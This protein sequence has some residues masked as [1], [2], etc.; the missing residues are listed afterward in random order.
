MDRLA[1]SAGVPWAGRHFS[2]T[3]F[4][5]DD[6]SAPPGL[7]AAL[8]ALRAG[9]G[10]QAEVL[11]ALRGVRLLVPLL[12]QLGESGVGPTGLT[13]DKSA[14][15]ALVTVAAPDGRRVLPTFTS[16]DAMRRWNPSARPIPVESERIALAAAAEGT[17]LVVLD[18]LSETEFVVRR[19]A[20]W[21]LG[22]GLPWRPAAGDPE[23]QAAFAEG[24]GEPAVRG[25]RLDAG[26]PAATLA[27]PE[28]VVELSLVD[29]LDRTGLD[30]LL[31]RIGE[32]WASSPVIAERVDSL[33]VRV[34]STRSS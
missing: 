30:A 11:E 26:D 29:G 1:D 19:P 8:T 13:V 7:L 23:V 34:V 22:R 17:D 14:E 20:V 5:G 18:P 31:A 16:V 25:V 12:A 3:A 10:G 4:S 32:R 33:A 15:L 2:P 27:G 24:A 9:T 6:G 28:L 21:A